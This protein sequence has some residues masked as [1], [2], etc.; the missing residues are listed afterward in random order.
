MA[1]NNIS[2][3]T[4]EDGSG[5]KLV[6]RTG[7][8]W[9]WDTRD[10]PSNIAILGKIKPLRKV[11]KNFFKDDSNGFQ[12]AVSACTSRVVNSDALDDFVR[13]IDFKN[14]KQKDAFMRQLALARPD[15]IQTR[16]VLPKMPNA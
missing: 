11:L 3:F 16:Y 14:E 10:I 1:A 13:G 12:A 4:H 2:E 15:Y 6:E 5:V 9:V 7:S 8:F